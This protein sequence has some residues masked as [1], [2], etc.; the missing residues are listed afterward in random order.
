M[1]K[2]DEKNT[3]RFEIAAKGEKEDLTAIRLD[4]YTQSCDQCIHHLHYR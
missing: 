3:C 1:V 2:Q 4:S